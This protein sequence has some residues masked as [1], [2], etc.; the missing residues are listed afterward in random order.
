MNARR[1]GLAIAIGTIALGGIV[2]AQPAEPDEDDRP[3]AALGD[4][5]V[6]ATPDAAPKEPFP[7]PPPTA[8]GEVLLASG[9]TWQV[10]LVMA[11]RPARA[12]AK[13]VLGGLDVAAGKADEGVAIGGDDDLGATPAG[14]PLTT[15]AGAYDAVTPLA[16]GPK[17]EC[18]CT[19]TFEELAAIGEGDRVAL[20]WGTTRFDLHRDDLRV[21][22]LGVRYTDG[23]VVWINGVEVARRRVAQAARPMEMPTLARGYEWENFHVPVTPGLLRAGE[24]VIAVAVRPSGRSSGPRLDVQLVGHA[25]A[26]LARGPIL[27]E[28]TSTSAKI[29]VET[30][31]PATAAIEWGATASLGQRVESTSGIAK[32]HVIALPELP[33]AGLVHYRA[34][35]DGAVTPTRTFRTMPTAGHPVRIAVYGDVRGGHL[36]HASLVEQMR[37]DDP[38]FVLATGDLVRS[39]SD[40][41]DWQRFFS[42]TGEMLATI[43]FWSAP[44]NHDIGRSGESKRRFSDLF[45]LPDLVKGAEDRPAWYGWSSFDAGDVHVVLLDS[46]GYEE[47]DQLDWL[48][49]DLAAA[50][51][52]GTKVIIAA[53]HEGPYSR[54]EHGGNSRAQK[55]FVPLLVKYGAALILSGHDHIYQRG[56]KDGLAYILSGGGGAPLYDVRCTNPDKKCPVKDGM[57]AVAKEHHYVL[58]TAYEKYIEACAKRP[59]GTALEPCVKI[60]VP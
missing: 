30:D 37:A 59:D 56:K 21:L 18:R 32:H 48:K 10:A 19:T 11:P 28:V 26:A 3:E 23:V 52:R 9:S 60:D 31:L 54:G 22:D 58:L 2:L 25:E 17:E 8:G 34:V 29:V 7:A 46:N 12:V 13:V 6:E 39:G 16:L 24:N 35:I 57:Q 15:P 5:G 40:D 4:A 42:V 53:T 38:D 51:K 20:L 55:K 49:L 33:E 44:G 45:L 27:G 36:T 41:G 43:P 47:R 14:W 1:R 50:K